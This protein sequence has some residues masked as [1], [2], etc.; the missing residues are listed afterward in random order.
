MAACWADTADDRPAGVAL[1]RYFKWL[2]ADLL[3]CRC[4]A[5]RMTAGWH[6][7]NVFFSSGRGGGGG[8]RSLH[9]RLAARSGRPRTT[10]FTSTIVCVCA[11]KHTLDQSLFDMCL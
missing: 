3:A 7:A 4:G 10:H 9:D 8:L 2:S 5:C 11:C 6:V 1:V